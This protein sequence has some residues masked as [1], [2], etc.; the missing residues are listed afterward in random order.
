MQKKQ[1]TVSGMTCSACQ[2]RVEKAVS[3]IEGV[4]SCTVNLISGVLKVETECDLTQKI[5]ESVKA[6]GYGVKEGVERKKTSER[7]ENLK[8]RLIISIPLVVILMYVAMGGMIGLPTPKFFEIPIAFASVQAVIALVVVIVNFSYFKIGF[9]NLF[10]LK[11]NMDSLVA[12]GSTAS[13]LYGVFAIVM[14]ALKIDVHKYYHNL[15]FEGSAMIVTLI[16]LGK[17]L[18]EKSKNKTMDAVEKL[19]GLTPDKAIVLVDG[20][21]VEVKTKD[22]KVGD[23]IILKDGFSIP[24]DGEIIEGDGEVDESM[25]TGESI[26]VFKKVG[27]KVICG[28]KF[29]GGFAKVEAKSVGEDTTVY[30]IV[31]LVEDANSTKV[32]IASI[33]D[34]VAGVFV[35]VVIGI[36]LTMLI[37][38]LIIS[39]D[40]ATAVNIAVSVLVVSCP[41]ALGLATPTALMVGTGKSAEN[42]ILVKSG[43]ALQNSAKIDT[44]VLDKTGTITKGSPEVE[45]VVVLDN[46]ER[47][48]FL[49]ICYSLE[50]KSSHVLS[51]SVIE[52]AKK[53]GAKT[54]EVE[55]YEVVRGKGVCGEIDGETYAFGN[56][57]LI[58]EKLGKD[59]FENAKK[60]IQ[61]ESSATLLILASSS[62]IMGY[63]SII[64]GIKESSI[65][66]ISQFKRMGIDVL[67][68]TGDNEK[69]AKAVA[70]RLGISYKSEVL[71]EDKH[72]EVKRLIAEGRSVMMVGD[73]VNDAPALREATVGVAIGAGTDIAIESADIVL[74]KNDL[75]DCAKGIFLGKAVMRN[76]KQNLFW[77]FFYN[78]LLIP[79]ACGVLSPFGIL[80]NPMLASAA[81]SAS[82]LFV[83]GNALRLR[84][85][86]FENKG[87]KE[88]FGK[89]KVEGKVAKIDGMMCVHCQKRVED[90]FKKFGIT[91]QIDLKKKT[92]TY[93]ISDVSDEEIKKAIEAEGYTVIS[94]E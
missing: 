38:W 29:S 59:S 17:F 12:L 84:L 3:K 87:D 80:L 89:K 5:I 83:V 9:K 69:S 34:K 18:E 6:E 25:I 77:A 86:K 66:A 2:A 70:E 94:I 75:S 15:Y 56:L 21:E 74:I 61:N 40:F 11:P 64:D 76:I 14:I 67:M 26:P 19:I 37:L 1:F 65:E 20:K 51:R 35:P 90:V 33:A 45:K 16:S 23:I 28:T 36:S 48:K 13:F 81:M 4:T 44:V 54:C 55:K 30:K 46:I 27:E 10:K 7:E 82:S 24:V 71:P 39:K 47:E 52:L 63:M 58:K 42:G 60:V 78:V 68:L 43:E 88:M 72:S 8:K 22:L 41:C 62:Q 85:I 32:P 57:T 73:G 49:S 91:A 93:P 53:E 50:E 79:L 31:K 92:A